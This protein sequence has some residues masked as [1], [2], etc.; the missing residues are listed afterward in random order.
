MPSH[1]YTSSHTQ[2]KKRRI[3]QKNPNSLNQN[4]FEC[5]SQQFSRSFTAFWMAIYLQHQVES[6]RLPISLK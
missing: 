2:A 4:L 6:F 3:R 1:Y 5:S